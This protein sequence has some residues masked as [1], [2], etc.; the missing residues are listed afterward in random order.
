MAIP[1]SDLMDSRQ[2]TD[3]CIP[4]ARR[5]ASPK[6]YSMRWTY[7]EP[8]CNR[9]RWIKAG[10]F[11]TLITL[12]V[13][14][15][16]WVN[17]DLVVR[18]GFCKQGTRNVSSYQ[19]P[20]NSGHWDR[21]VC[22]WLLQL[23]YSRW[24][25]TAGCCV[26]SWLFMAAQSYNQCYLPLS[27]ASSERTQMLSLTSWWIFRFK[28]LEGKGLLLSNSYWGWK[29]VKVFCDLTSTISFNQNFRQR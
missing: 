1:Y 24:L 9:A 17:Q 12:K 25:E 19:C 10:A 2:D 21:W 29:G 13:E 8:F 4:F 26:V 14:L 27:K 15:N 5:C 28:C 22:G 16:N 20:G 23:L 7:S 11:S 3:R 6:G 18:R